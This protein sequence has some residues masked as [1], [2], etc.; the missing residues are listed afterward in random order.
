M[1][2]DR[3]KRMDGIVD[4]TVATI[5]RNGLPN[6]RIKDIAAEAGVSERL[7]SYYYPDLDAL[8]AATHRKAS[9][10]Y[11]WNR[12]HA[13][14]QQRRPEAALAGLIASGVPQGRGDVLSRVLYELSVSATRMPQHERLMS[15]LYHD[16]VSL[17][18]QVLEQGAKTEAFSLAGTYNELARSFV[19]LEDGL[20]LQVLAGTDSLTPEQAREILLGYARAVTGAVL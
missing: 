7:V 4:A 17:Y 10:K 8:V 16:E 13:L 3:D 18:E 9:E 6:L 19:A 1:A 15:S 11:Y 14:Q 12:L 5:A 20:G 2:R